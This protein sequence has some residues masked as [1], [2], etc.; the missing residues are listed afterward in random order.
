[1][2]DLRYTRQVFRG[3]LN[4]AY[5]GERKL[6][7]YKDLEVRKQ[8]Q[9]EYSKKYYEK[10]KAA[11]MA[12]VNHN[13]KTMRAW[14]RKF[15][16]TKACITC[17]EDHPATI[18]FHHVNPQRGDKKVNKLVSDGHNKKTVQREIEKCVPMCSNCHRKHHFEERIAR[19]KAKKKKLAKK[20]A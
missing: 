17:G 14:F 7:P 13:K 11:I 3:P 10:N 15:K 20:K 18:D 4:T 5:T 2:Q 9:A 1:M 16:A 8:K 12:R 19:V 6:M